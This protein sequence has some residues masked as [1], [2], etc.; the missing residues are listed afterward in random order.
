MDRLFN[1]SPSTCNHQPSNINHS[2]SIRVNFPIPLS[3]DSP[4][5]M[6]HSLDCDLHALV[7]ILK[8]WID[9]MTKALHACYTYCK[10]FHQISFITND[11]NDPNDPDDPTSF[12]QFCPAKLFTRTFDAR[13]NFGLSILLSYPIL[14]G[15]LVIL[16]TRAACLKV[17]G[18]SRS[19]TNSTYLCTDEYS[20]YQENQPQYE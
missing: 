2:H 17:I 18:Y 12:F 4:S 14:L 15:I 8:S 19:M 9:W 13:W 6:L 1:L 20:A 10:W 3:F 7:T 16:V 5:M 11:P